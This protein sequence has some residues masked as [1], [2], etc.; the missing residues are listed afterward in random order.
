MRHI[1]QLPGPS[2]SLSKWAMREKGVNVSTKSIFGAGYPRRYDNELL[3]FAGWRWA[4]H[5]RMLLMPQ[6]GE[7]M[8]DRE[9]ECRDA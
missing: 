5:N 9:G 6:T 1:N 3:I 2:S 8:Y 4:C 7:Q